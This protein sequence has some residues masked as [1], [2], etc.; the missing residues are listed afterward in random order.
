MAQT[1]YPG[2][3]IPGPNLVEHRNSEPQKMI[4]GTKIDGKLIHNK[5]PLDTDPDEHI[6]SYITFPACQHLKR[7]LS[8]KASGVVLK[9]YSTAI[10]ICHMEPPEPRAKIPRTDNTPVPGHYYYKD[11][12][13]LDQRELYR[14]R[15]RILRCNDCHTNS[16]LYMCLQCPNVGCLSSGHAYEHARKSG[17]MF[18]KFQLRNGIALTVLIS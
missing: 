3:T 14:I 16:S 15:A 8:S 5:R 13:A 4:D 12:H 2:K 6:E 10:K 18:G 7:V 1:S 11:G 9:T 17:H